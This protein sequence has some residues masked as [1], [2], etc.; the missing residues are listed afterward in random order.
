MWLLDTMLPGFVGPNIHDYES[1]LSVFSDYLWGLPTVNL[2]NTEVYSMWG[3]DLR[4]S[5]IEQV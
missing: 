4:T 5:D 2:E 1:W 3:Q